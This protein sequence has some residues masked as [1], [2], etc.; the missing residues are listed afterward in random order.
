VIFKLRPAL[1]PPGISGAGGL[2]LVQNFAFS[3][4]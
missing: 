2:S 4:E 1:R 3:D